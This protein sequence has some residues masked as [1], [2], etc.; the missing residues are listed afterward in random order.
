MES[1]TEMI[2]AAVTAAIAGIGAYFAAKANTQAKQANQAVNHTGPGSK[3][4]YDII[5]QTDRKVDALDGRIY[6]LDTRTQNLSDVILSRPCMH[7]GAKCNVQSEKQ[8]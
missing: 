8:D 4:L 2:A 1:V 5:D 3:R 7:T 6:T